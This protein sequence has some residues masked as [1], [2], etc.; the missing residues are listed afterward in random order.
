MLLSSMLLMNVDCAKISQ[1]QVIKDGPGSSGAVPSPPVWP[2][3]FEV[4]VQDRLSF[5]FLHA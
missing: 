5:A 2:S 1:S 4:C 3:T